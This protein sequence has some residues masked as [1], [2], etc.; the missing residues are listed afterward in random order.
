MY[1]QKLLNNHLY[2]YFFMLCLCYNYLGDLM[3]IINSEY[4][5][6]A[7]EI[8]KCPQD[9]KP[10]FLFVGRSNVG[11]STLINSLTNNNK[12]ARTSSSPGKTQT[13]VFF[14]INNAEF[15]IVDAPG[16][17]FAKVPKKIREKFASMM[18]QYL[19]FRENLKTTF[20]LV[21]SRHNP[22]KDDL[23]MYEYIKYFGHDY[24][25]V[26]TKCD[27]HSNNQMT[28]VRKNMEHWF[29][30]SH[31]IYVS[32]V[33]KRGVEEILQYMNKKMS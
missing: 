6:Q 29:P 33:D 15:R 3:K 2:G 16:Y 11:K 12:L 25:I 21:D 31:K 27:K 10:E 30:E 17:G 13:L 26:V 32:S 19:E 24:V 4:L 9:E 1:L 14:N 20:M 23:A 7:V 18:D 8:T 22:S 5:I 28:K